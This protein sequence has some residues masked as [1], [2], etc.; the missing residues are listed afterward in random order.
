MARKE[1]NTTKDYFL[2]GDR[3]P[4][5][6]IGSSLTA[7][8]ISAEHFVGMIGSAY[9]AGLVVGNMEWGNFITYTMLVWVFLP[10]YMRGGLYTMPEFLENRFNRTTRYFY[11]VTT[12][13]TYILGFIAAILY[14]GALVLEALFGIPLFWG[15]LLI[16]FTTSIYTVYG[17]LMS[18]V[19]AEFVQCIVLFAGGI[20]VTSFGLARVGGIAPLIAEFPEKFYMAYPATDPNF[21]FAGMVGTVLSVS[22]WYVCTNQFMVQRCLGA[23]SEWDARMGGIMAG[24]YKLVLP[25]IICLPGIIAFKVLGPGVDPNHVFPLLVAELIPVGLIGLIMAGLASAIMST[26]SSTLNA[27][28]TVVTMDILKPLVFKDASEKKLVLSGRLSSVFMMLFSIAVALWFCVERGQVFL[29]IQNIYSYFAAPVAALF[30]LGIFWKGATQ[31]AATVTFISGFTLNEIMD[32]II[33]KIALFSNYDSFYNRAT[34]VF[35]FSLIIMTVVSLFTKK[36]DPE[37]VNSICWRISDLKLRGDGRS[38]HGTGSL[39][40]FWFF[41]VVSIMSVYA[42]LFFL[43]WRG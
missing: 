5:Y 25:L 32:R 36:S 10:Y 1:K 41:M 14:A 3:L 37:V 30:L 9:A 4:W 16:A 2:A 35:I 27:A 15:V 39:A 22:M 31:T 20:I 8:N 7:S 43:Q 34:M 38:S 17:G 33:F 29:I 6:V 13:L 23:R 21:P 42:A 12:L 18:V 40:F 26:V 19:W 24:Y 28:S 11:A